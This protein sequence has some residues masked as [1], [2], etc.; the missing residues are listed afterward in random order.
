VL[1][2]ATSAVLAPATILSHNLLSQLRILRGDR[3]LLDRVSVVLM[4]IGSLLIAFTDNSVMELLD[5]S[6]SIPLVALFVPLVMGLW[7]RPRGEM[8]AILSSLL[9]LAAWTIPVAFE[10]LIAPMPAANPATGEPYADYHAFL[11]QAWSPERVG[12]LV[13]SLVIWMNVISADILGTVASFGGYFLGQW[14][15]RHQP[16][17]EPAARVPPPEPLSLSSPSSESTQ[18]PK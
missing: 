7:F 17:R 4:T 15:H 2:T 5:G 6:L 18:E 1:P 8:S 10:T 13:S 3:L 16:A 14:I 12:S 11:V 9:G